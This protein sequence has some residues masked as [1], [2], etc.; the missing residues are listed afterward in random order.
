[1]VPNGPKW[2]KIIDHKFNRMAFITRS[3]LVLVINFII[4]QFKNSVITLSFALNLFFND[5]YYGRICT[6]P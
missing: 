5:F 1:M 4:T 6:K 3:H 2:S